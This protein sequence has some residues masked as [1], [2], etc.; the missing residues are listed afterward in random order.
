VSRR[1]ALM[2]LLLFSTSASAATLN[3]TLSCGRRGEAGVL[4]AGTD[5]TRQTVDLRKYPEAVCNDATPAVFYVSPHTREED[6]NKW[7]IFLQGGGGCGG[8][9]ECANRWCSSGTNVGMDKMSSSLSKPSINGSG[10]FERRES[11]RFHGWNHVLVY[12]CIP[13]TG[14]ETN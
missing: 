1:F 7:V 2:F 10:I 6:R 4:A 8:G 14:P 13:T 5:M 12:Y 3:Q 11:N 9:D